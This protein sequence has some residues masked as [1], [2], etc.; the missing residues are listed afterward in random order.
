LDSEEAVDRILERAPRDVRALV[1]KGDHRTQA[2]DD[3]AA[4]AFYRAALRAAAADPRLPHELAPYVERAQAR[5]AVAAQSFERHLE[6][7]LIAA[8]FPE[9]KR[10][11]RFQE[12]VEI[13][14]GRRQ[15]R[16]QLQRPGGYLYP[17]LPQR[18]YYEREEFD[19][20]GEV[21]SMAVAMREELTAWL[22]SGQD[23]FT[24]Y[25]VKDPTRPAHDFHGMV[26]NPEWSTLYLWQNGRAVEE[27]VAHCP[28][29]F[30]TITR[31]DVPFITTRAPSILFSRLSP[32]ARIPPHTGVLNTRLICH[33]PLIVPPGCGFRVGGETRAWEEG[34][35]LVFDDTVE[36]EAWNH[37]DRDRILLI[38]D[39]WRPELDADERRAVTALFEAV[40]SYVR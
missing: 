25:M 30:E 5:M 3:R 31:L 38:F 10:P 20:A 40:D 1:L 17:G 16:L 37:G 9:G 11:A 13:L 28:R 35:L 2:G 19:W 12:S 29:T 36:H 4:T 33:L 26:D 6:A 23:R 18:R 34:R 21:E 22:A 15:V 14:T 27:H 8:G 39:I 24:P 32:G 7:S